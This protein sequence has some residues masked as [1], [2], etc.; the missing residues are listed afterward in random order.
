MPALLENL[1]GSVSTSDAGNGIGYSGIRIRGSDQSRI[2]V[3]I[4]GVPVN[5][6]ESQNVFW[7]DLPD[8][9]EDVEMV[10]V[11]RGVECQLPPEHLVPI[12]ICRQ[13][14]YLM[15]WVYLPMPVM[16]PLTAKNMVLLIVP[17]DSANISI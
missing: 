17:A 8:L 12:L 16:A 5:D 7:V 11:Q 4:H 3:T 9:I 6:A 13:A 14:S 15:T 1:P 2:N 10:Q